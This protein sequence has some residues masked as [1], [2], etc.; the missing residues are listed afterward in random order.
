[1]NVKLVIAAASLVIISGCAGKVEAVP[2]Y[3]ENEVACESCGK[4]ES[5]DA[6]CAK[7]VKV[8][9]YKD[10]CQSGCGFPVTVRKHSTCKYEGGM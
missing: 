5:V 4:N 7:E 8:I 9:K 6:L 3:V 10:A 2:V 1:M